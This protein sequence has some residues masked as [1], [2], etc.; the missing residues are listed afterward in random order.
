MPLF[1]YRCQNCNKRFTLLVGVLAETRATSCPACGSIKLI[2]LMSRFG[3][4]R[5]EDAVLDDLADIDKV[6][7][8][9]DPKKLRKWIRE[10]GKS[11]DDDSGDDLEE[12]LEAAAEEETLGGHSADGDAIY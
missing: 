2:K 3:S 12:M 6:G 11:M 8:V 4:P 1:E 5:S 7:D 9:E 10:M